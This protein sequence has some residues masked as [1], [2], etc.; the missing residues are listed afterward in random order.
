M[1]HGSP[2]PGPAANGQR[3]QQQYSMRSTPFLPLTS[4]PALTPEASKYT[5]ALAIFTTSCPIQ[6]SSPAN[7]PLSRRTA[8][9]S[10]RGTPPQLATRDTKLPTQA[11]LHGAIPGHSNWSDNSGVETV[12]VRKILSPRRGRAHSMELVD[13]QRMNKTMTKKTITKRTGRR[14]TLSMALGNG[15]GLTTQKRSARS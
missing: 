12:Y 15:D 1:N 3:L 7:D 9:D 5:K 14:I 11:Q 6:L 13:H 2:P 10:M 8:K 4:H